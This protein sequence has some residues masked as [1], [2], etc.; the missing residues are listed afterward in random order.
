VSVLKQKQ[1]RDKSMEEMKKKFKE[2]KILNAFEDRDLKFRKQKAL[3]TFGDVKPA[4]HVAN[5]V[6]ISN[7]FRLILMCVLIIISCCITLKFSTFP[8]NM[9]CVF[10]EVNFHISLFYDII[11]IIYSHL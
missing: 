2:I 4:V 8:V 10:D 3:F 11:Y 6:Q 7:K 5:K 9:T 1:S